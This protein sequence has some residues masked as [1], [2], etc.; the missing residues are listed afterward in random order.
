MNLL[1]TVGV[2]D[3][4]RSHPARRDQCR[5]LFALQEPDRLAVIQDL[6]FLA[7][8]C[9]VQR[10]GPCSQTHCKEVVSMAD[11]ARLTFMEVDARQSIIPLYI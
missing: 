10:N 11:G 6:V 8:H 1:A 5:L 2:P 3:L 9:M 4:N 7:G